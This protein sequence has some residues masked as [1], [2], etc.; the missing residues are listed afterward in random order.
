MFGAST[1]EGTVYQ[2]VDL[3]SCLRFLTVLCSLLS[4]TV[5]AHLLLEHGRPDSAPSTGQARQD[6][7]SNR[8]I[9]AQ[10]QSEICSP[11]RT[12]HPF[13]CPQKSMFTSVSKCRL[14][15]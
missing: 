6:T 15:T 1:V 11:V 12:H 9:R 10:P 8:L 2:Y 5:D 14:L 3:P 4:T 13:C 7:L